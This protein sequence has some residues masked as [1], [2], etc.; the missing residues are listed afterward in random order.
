MIA[1]VN[2]F[3]WKL[4]PHVVYV[5]TG[6]VYT[7][8]EEIVRAASAAY[9]TVC[10]LAWTV[11]KVFEQHAEV[12]AFHLWRGCLAT[13]A[14]FA[15]GALLYGVWRALGRGVGAPEERL[16]EK[17]TAFMA[18][19]KN[20]STMLKV[21]EMVAKM[22]DGYYQVVRSYPTEG[23]LPTMFQGGCPYCLAAAYV[24]FGDTFS[25]VALTFIEQETG[26]KELQNHTCPYNL[27]VAQDGSPLDYTYFTALLAFLAEARSCVTLKDPRSVG[28]IREGKKGKTKRR[29]LK[30]MLSGDWEHTVN[31][32]E[33]RI[34]SIKRRIDDMEQEIAEAVAQESDDPRDHA[35]IQYMRSRLQHEVRELHVELNEY[36]SDSQRGSRVRDALLPS[37]NR[38]HGDDDDGVL[39]G[40]KTRMEIPTQTEL[41]SKDKEVLAVPTRR[42]MCLQAEP[43]SRREF[44]TQTDCIP[45]AVVFNESPIRREAGGRT[46]LFNSDKQVTLQ[47]HEDVMREMAMAMARSDRSRME[48][49][50]RVSEATSS[51]ASVSTGKG[52]GKRE[53]AMPGSTPMK[54]GGSTVYVTDGSQ[55]R[56]GLCARVNDRLAVGTCRHANIDGKDVDYLYTVNTS[57]EV[58]FPNGRQIAPVVVGYWAPENTKDEVWYLFD[59]MAPPYV[60]KA[61]VVVP[62]VA[63]VGKVV[64]MYSATCSADGV[65]EWSE[66][67]GVV[68]SV[69]GDEVHYTATTDDGYCR[70]PVYGPN[71]RVLA[72]HLY[73]GKRVGN[74]PPCNAGEAYHMPPNMSVFKTSIEPVEFEV[75]PRRQGKVVKQAPLPSAEVATLFLREEPY[76]IWPLRSDKL[77]RGVDFSY[78]YMKPSTELNKKELARFGDVLEYET[79]TDIMAVALEA[80]IMMDEEVLTPFNHPTFDNVL[81]MIANLDD[82]TKTAGFTADGRTHHE[83]L[84][85]LG[86]GDLEAG[87]RVLTRRVL[88]LYEY[89]CGDDTSPEAQTLWEQ[90]THWNVMGKKDGYKPNKLNVGRT[91]QCPSMEMKVLWK[92]CYGLADDR[93]CKRDPEICTRSW[94]HAGVDFDRPVVGQRKKK[95]LASCGAGALDATAFDRYMEPYYIDSFMRVHMALIAPGAPVPFLKRMAEY[96]KTGPLVMCDG[97]VYFKNRG[98]PSGFMNT[99]RLNCWANLLAWCYCIGR[100]LLEMGKPCL[101]SHIEDVLVNHLYVEICGDD[102]RFWAMTDFGAQ[103][104]DL[105]NGMA[106]VMRVWNEELPWSVK[107]E[108]CESWPAGGCATQ[109]IV[110]RAPT[111]VSRCLFWQG[112]ILWE[113]L[114]NISRCL[115][116]LCHDDGRTAAEEEELVVSAYATLAVPVFLHSQ[117]LYYSA[118]LQALLDDFPGQAYMD[119]AYRRAARLYS[120]C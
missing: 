89:M 80:A 63:D 29:S 72:G 118:P 94:V 68:K 97:T 84:I 95:I 87:T 65:I 14:L 100:R 16:C 58:H 9:I 22:D 98:N 45:K 53:S 67:K 90:C 24:C 42:D 2:E 74:G 120:Y 46:V 26:D 104:L 117:G 110:E 12:W 10:W 21:R 8:R 7:H 40:A 69:K 78:H 102:S 13:I 96:I 116:H 107:L 47:P 88:Q 3:A 70:T 92:T 56:M 103:L 30:T 76:K 71:G 61:I 19:V 64:N 73:G 66:T 99:L 48:H 6:L 11:R 83:Y 108:G 49:Q 113:T 18:I 119:V 25:K 31:E 27:H 59:V 15:M 50:E 17:P 35:R 77:M 101:P 81:E 86:S 106:A 36:A 93:W 43:C 75:I 4:A 37:L 111:M 82:D 44:A 28:P 85:F 115:K 60:G 51:N 55:P 91:I 52:K 23:M 57:V 33:D 38:Y 105:P 62:T 5:L 20:D 32:D 114:S 34:Q 39:E 1:N 109:K 112:N 41:K 79:N 54:L